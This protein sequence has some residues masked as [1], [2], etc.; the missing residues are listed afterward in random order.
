MKANDASDPPPDPDPPPPP[1][2]A[3]VEEMG[4]ESA[5][6]LHRFWDP[7]DE[8]PQGSRRDAE[9]AES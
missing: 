3:E 5:C 2:V 8:E 6:Q 4:G 1:P 9:D 7:D